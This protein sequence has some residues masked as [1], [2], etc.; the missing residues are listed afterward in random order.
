MVSVITIEEFRSMC[1]SHMHED[2]NV[3]DVVESIVVV[4]DESMIDIETT[5]CDSCNCNMVYEP[6]PYGTDYI[7]LCSRDL[8]YLNTDS[9]M[10]CRKWKA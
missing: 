5:T 6:C 1:Y 7:V 3:D 8:N 9:T 10:Y 4:N 2:I